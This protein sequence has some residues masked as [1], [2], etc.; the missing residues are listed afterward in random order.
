MHYF[1]RN[2]LE[3]YSL[4]YRSSFL[5]Y[6]V[7][8]IFT[9]SLFTFPSHSP[10]S[11]YLSIPISLNHSFPLH[12]LLLFHHLGGWYLMIVC[13]QAAHIWMCRT[14]TVSIFQHGIFSNRV[15]NFGVII[16]LLLGCFVTYTPGTVANCVPSLKFMHC[17]VR[18]CVFIS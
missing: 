14:T 13:G 11:I 1:S 8:I 7:F 16:A 3:H 9:Q 5:F 6:I 18:L 12:P 17:R 4:L 15:T 10:H 2:V